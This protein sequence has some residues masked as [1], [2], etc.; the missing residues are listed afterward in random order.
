MPKGSGPIRASPETFTTT[1]RKVGSAMVRP[2]PRL[3]SR[4]R[5]EAV[6]RR[7]GI[8]SAL[9]GGRSD[10]GREI[11]VRPVDAFAQRIAHVTRDLDRGGGLGLGFLDRLRHA[12]VR[13]VDIGLIEQTDL[14]VEGLEP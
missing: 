13:L 2:L 6:R 12:L 4:A 9:P 8:S 14:L 7:R 5:R 10:L 1:R 11:G 3:S